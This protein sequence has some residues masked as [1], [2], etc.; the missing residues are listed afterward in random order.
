MK[1]AAANRATQVL[2]ATFVNA[3]GEPGDCTRADRRPT[4]RWSWRPRVARRSRC[5]W[6]ARESKMWTGRMLPGSIVGS[7]SGKR[8]PS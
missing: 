1:S 8:L 7:S 6:R 4:R 3:G 2:F 5:A